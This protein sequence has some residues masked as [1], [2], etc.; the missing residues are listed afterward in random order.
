MKNASVSTG[1][2]FMVILAQGN[3]TWEGVGKRSAGWR[4]SCVGRPTCRQ[5][6]NRNRG[7]L[8]RAR[9]SISEYEPCPIL[10]PRV[11]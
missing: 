2:F 4:I 3:R 9:D 7:F 10:L 11:P 6:G 1:V 8:W 5:A